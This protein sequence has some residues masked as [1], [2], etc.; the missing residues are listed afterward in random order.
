MWR[1]MSILV[2]LSAVTINLLA[3][4]RSEDKYNGK[5]IP[6]QIQELLIEILEENE[7]ANIEEVVEQLEQLLKNP[8]DIN[9]ALKR[10]LES[11][12]ILNDFQI[13]MIY[14]TGQNMVSL[15]LSMK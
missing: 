6:S 7:N 1:K 10:D 2:L 15:P 11:L 12:Y 9:K 13:E 3:Q 14:H 5:E 4:S 8:I